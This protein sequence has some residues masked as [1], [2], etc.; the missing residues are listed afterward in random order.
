MR[1]KICENEIQKSIFPSWNF[2]NLLQTKKI[3]YGLHVKAIEITTNYISH[4]LLNKHAKKLL[5]ERFCLKPLSYVI[6]F[7][8]ICSRPSQNVKFGD[9]H[10]VVVQ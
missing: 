3:H 8:W 10:V 4:I 7:H 6:P 5:V 2:Y 9:L 1:L